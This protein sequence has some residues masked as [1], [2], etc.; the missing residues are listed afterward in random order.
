MGM[1]AVQGACAGSRAVPGRGRCPVPIG[2][3]VSVCKL[4]LW[5][6]RVSP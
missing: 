6:A 4:S 3:D 5:A 1:A 2:K